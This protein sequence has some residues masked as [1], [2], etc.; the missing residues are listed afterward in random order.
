[1]KVFKDFTQDDSFL[2]KIVH[3]PVLDITGAVFDVTMKKTPDDTS[4]ALS[5]SYTAPVGTDAT[6][7]IA[8]IPITREDTSA[9]QEGDYYASIKRT[10]GNSTLTLIQTDKANNID[11]V[12][13][14]KTLTEKVV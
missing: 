3:N 10:I 6:N 5:V 8:Y 13:V 4:E 9:V 7:G 2:I 1:M 14:T 11:K 12:R